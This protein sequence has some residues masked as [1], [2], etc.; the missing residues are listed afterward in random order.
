MS[1][2]DGESEERS[3]LHLHFK[4]PPRPL[5]AGHLMVSDTRQRA[6]CPKFDMEISVNKAA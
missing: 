5:L 3:Q 4:P 1:E 6:T 2:G